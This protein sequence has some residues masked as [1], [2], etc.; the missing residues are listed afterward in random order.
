MKNFLLRH[1]KL[2]W[3][4]IAVVALV[5][6]RYLYA[7][8]TVGPGMIVILRSMYRD[9]EVGSLRAMTS[10]GTPFLIARSIGPDCCAEPERGASFE[11]AAPD[12][13]QL[14]EWVEFEWQ[15]WPYPLSRPSDP[16]GIKRWESTVHELSKNLPYKKA[17]VLIRSRVP[18]AV[19]D[20]IIAAKHRQQRDK[21]PDRQLELQFNW[22][23]D[24]VRLRWRLT[25]R[26]PNTPGTTTLRIGGDEL[27]ARARAN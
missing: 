21:L 22:Y 6:A 12:G 19:V 10:S 1:L 3:V 26:E 8:C 20:E 25:A 27:P 24:A 23:E 9:K 5:E 17:R 16:E 15:E 18:R 2:I 13:R 7:Y 14:P 4:T 11:G